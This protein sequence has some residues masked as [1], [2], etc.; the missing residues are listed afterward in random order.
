[1][2]ALRVNK[3]EV[4]GATAPWLDRDG[5]FSSLGVHSAADG[6]QIIQS[7]REF[8]DMVAELVAA[9]LTNR[10]AFVLLR[11]FSQ[12]HVTHL[13]RANYENSGWAKQFDDVLVDGLGVGV[14]L[15]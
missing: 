7:A 6:P 10:A 13:L 12:G 5:D 3:L 8:V 9:G 4:L 2:E 1:M 14:E 15:L 11:A